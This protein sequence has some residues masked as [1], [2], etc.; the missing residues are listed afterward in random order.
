[1][2]KNTTILKPIGKNINFN[3]TMIKILNT[4]TNTDV[5]ILF[6]PNI[7]VL[8][9]GEILIDDIC[10]PCAVLSNEKR[11]LFQRDFLGILTGN[12]KGGLDRYLSASNLQDFLSDR[13]R[14]KK[15]NQIFLS[16]KYGR[17]TAYGLNSEDVIEILEMYLK[18]RDA[19][20]LLKNQEHLAIKAEKIMRIFAKVGLVALIDEATGYQEYRKKDALRLLV[21]S[22]IREDARKWTKEFSDDFFKGL[23]KIYRLNTEPRTRPKFYGKFIN[24]YIYDPIEK[25]VILKELKI[26][27]GIDKNK[28]LHQ[29]LTDDKGLKVLN[30]RI[31]RVTTLL[32]ISSTLED[33]NRFYEKSE[34]KQEHFEFIDE[35]Q[36]N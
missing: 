4:N 10:I 36:K 15:S 1:M 8:Y 24:K 14:N 19:G 7:E 30:N 13:L 35:L 21:E 26:L 34:Y 23:D 32:D 22:Y 28:R 18:A 5:S 25:G 17:H 20:K 2:P 11:V 33:F 3:E 9:K 12:K 27:K 29:F 16:F 6:D 31:T